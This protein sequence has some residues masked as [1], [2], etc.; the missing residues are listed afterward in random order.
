[1]SNWASHT[2]ELGSSFIKIWTCGSSQRSGSRNAWRK[3]RKFNGAC[4]LS[5]FLNFW[6]AIQMI[7]CRSRLLTMNKIWLYHYDPE[8]KQELMEGLHS[9]S[10]RPKIFLV[11][12]SPG[13]F[14]NRFFDIKKAPS[15]LII[16]QMAKLST[17]SITHLCWCNWRTFW[18]KNTARNSPR[19]SCSWTA[20][21]RLTGHL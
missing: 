12:K 9:G 15:P 10:L 20:K 2:S 17:R 8:I 18:R 1:M 7:S 14:S 11:Q 13:K 5:K 4:S 21:L 19:W 3:I 6:E 16:F